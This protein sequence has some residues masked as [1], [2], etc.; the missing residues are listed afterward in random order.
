[1]D[2]EKNLIITDISALSEEYSDVSENK[3]NDDADNALNNVG[4][5]I[6]KQKTVIEKTL[7]ENNV[8]KTQQ[9]MNNSSLVTKKTFASKMRSIYSKEQIKSIVKNPIFIVA[10][11]YMLFPIDIFPDG[12]PI[13]GNLDDLFVVISGVSGIITTY[14]EKGV[15]DAVES[16]VDLYKKIDK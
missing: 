6:Q 3:V 8:N 10:I 11:I 2:N 16:A 13:I 4:K 1:M 5:Y 9:A 7:V 12:V 15:A 14:K